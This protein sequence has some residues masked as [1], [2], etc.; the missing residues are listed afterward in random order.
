MK[1]LIATDIH[2]SGK[3]A[4]IIKEKFEEQKA[5]KLVLLGDL[6]YHGARNEL[7]DGYAPKHVTAVLNSL[8]SKVIAVKGNCDSEV[9][10]MVLDFHINESAMIDI[11]GKSVLLTHGHHINPEA[12]AKLGAGS[13]VLYGHFHVTKLTNV[14]GVT[15]INISSIT[16]PKHDSVKSYGIL[17]ESGVRVFDLDDKEILSYKF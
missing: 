17:D 8:A 15:Y 1:Y 12:P 6:L 9:D 3:S 2:G 7:P 14:E 11:A 10:Q 5:D 16:L 4:D 13:V